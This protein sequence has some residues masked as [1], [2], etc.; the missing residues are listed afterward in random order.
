LKSMTATRLSPRRRRPKC[1][2]LRLAV[3]PDY[4]VTAT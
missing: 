3:H 4:Q 1:V 2:A